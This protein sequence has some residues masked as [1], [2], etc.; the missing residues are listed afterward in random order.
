M[1]E[2]NLDENINSVASNL[3]EQVAKVLIRH[4]SILDVMTKLHEYNSRI[5]RAVVKSVTSCGCIS[6]NAN[7]QEYGS[8]SF[9]EMLFTTQNHLN[10]EICDSCRDIVA[11][12]IGSYLFYLSALANALDLDIDQIMNKEYENIKTLGVFSLK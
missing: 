11:E 1:N 9:E 10:G 12:E 2:N 5:N 6:I 8:T 3:Q 7:K 4:K